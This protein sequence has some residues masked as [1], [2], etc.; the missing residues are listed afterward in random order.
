MLDTL[1]RALSRSNTR[2]TYGV[3]GHTHSLHAGTATRTWEPRTEA[4]DRDRIIDIRTETETPDIQTGKSDK[5]TDGHIR[6]TDRQ[7]D[8]QIRNTEIDQT[9]RHTCRQI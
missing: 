3:E 7:T 6:Q 8:R 4:S 1:A 5:N 2:L 9:R